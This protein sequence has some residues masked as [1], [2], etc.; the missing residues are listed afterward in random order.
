MNYTLN[1]SMIV[2]TKKSKRPEPK[3]PKDVN[4]LRLKNIKDPRDLNDLKMQ[5]FKTKR[6]GRA[7]SP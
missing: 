7:K 6:P 5:I 3:S 1:T 4:G 2:K